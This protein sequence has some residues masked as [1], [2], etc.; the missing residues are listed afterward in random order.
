MII[1]LI[2][3]LLIVILFYFKRNNNLM[4][5]ISRLE[6]FQSDIIEN[7]DFLMKNIFIRKQNTT[8][9]LEKHRKSY[10]S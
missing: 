2:S 8:K 1:L 4:N 6:S 3:L 7:F 5:S 10:Q 9:N